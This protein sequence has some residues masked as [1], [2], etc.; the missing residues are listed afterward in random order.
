M[1]NFNTSLPQN[2]HP[3]ENIPTWTQSQTFNL[4]LNKKPITN[5]IGARPSSNYFAQAENQ[6]KPI[7]S[8]REGI[9]NIS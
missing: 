3:S 5:N 9:V 7:P 6:Q 8:A 1:I 2:Y 4:D